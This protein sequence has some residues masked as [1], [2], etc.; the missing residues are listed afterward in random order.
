MRGIPRLRRTC[1]FPPSHAFGLNSLN[2]PAARLLA[3]L[4]ELEMAERVQRRIQ[5]HLAEAR[6]PAGKTL[7]SFDFE[8]TPENRAAV[9]SSLLLN[10]AWQNCERG[11]GAGD[12]AQTV[13]VSGSQPGTSGPT[14]GAVKAAI[15][16]PPSIFRSC[17]PGQVRN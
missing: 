9:E 7:D 5:R 4:C 11:K 16:F 14:R 17:G 3:T 10:F 6:L 13:G 12:P 15:R 8:I 2:G 1:G